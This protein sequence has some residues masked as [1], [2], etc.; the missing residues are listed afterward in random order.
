ML[1]KLHYPLT[2]LIGIAL[3]TA[4]ASSSAQAYKG[5]TFS[6]RPM[7]GQSS[8]PD[9]SVQ[10]RQVQGGTML[11]KPTFGQKFGKGSQAPGVNP[12]Q[13]MRQQQD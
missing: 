13:L 3:V 8:P 4:L 7:L 10:L 2:A 6:S 5:G 1:R 11:D 12:R 9:S